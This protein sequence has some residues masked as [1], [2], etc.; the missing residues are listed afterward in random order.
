VANHISAGTAY[1]S[2]TTLE[3]K[4]DIGL[5]DYNWIGGAFMGIR[6]WYGKN[7]TLAWNRKLW[8]DDTLPNFALPSGS[9]ARKA[10]IDLSRPF[11]I[12]GITYLALSGMTPG[13]F[14][15][16]RPDLGALQSQPG[17]PAPP[18]NLR[19]TP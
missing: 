2:G 9:D 1:N 19:S 11:T 4:K 6:K 16:S 10:G 13:Y 12:D 14:S 8:K 17:Q 15:G 3:L 18:T 5:F 7:N